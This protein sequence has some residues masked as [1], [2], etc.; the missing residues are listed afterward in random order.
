MIFS[1]LCDFNSSDNL[2]HFIYIFYR[3]LLYN[4]D[5]NKLINM[6]LFTKNKDVIFLIWI[7]H[8]DINHLC[9]FL[10]IYF[11]LII[12]IIVVK[13]TRFNNKIFINT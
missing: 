7:L 10:V 2:R 12:T 3:Y 4:N 11:F 1:L 5:N 13:T 8:N 9:A 6:L